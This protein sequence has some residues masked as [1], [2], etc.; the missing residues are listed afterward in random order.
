MIPSAT[1]EAWGID[2]RRT[3]GWKGVRHTDP[4]R[5]RGCLSVWFHREADRQRAL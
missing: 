2:G 5:S 3:R 1:A 4:L